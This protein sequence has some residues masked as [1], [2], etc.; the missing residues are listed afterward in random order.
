MSNA[1]E[2]LV[3]VV[4]T[5]RDAGYRLLDL[6]PGTAWLAEP[7]HGYRLALSACACE[8]TPILN[9]SAI[10]LDSV[11]A[12]NW[13]YETREHL[14]ALDRLGAWLKALQDAGIRQEDIHDQSYGQTPEGGSY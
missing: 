11:I 9:H 12:D 10:T 5:L 13:R 7:E 14:S 1:N 2:T 3:R 6:G 8:V 4:E